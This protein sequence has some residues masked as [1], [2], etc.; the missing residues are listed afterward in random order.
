M[1]SIDQQTEPLSALP[2]FAAQVV[3]VSPAILRDGTARITR[4]DARSFA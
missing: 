1:H 4:L 3:C 2:D